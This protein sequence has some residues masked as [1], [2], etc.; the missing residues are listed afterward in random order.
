VPRQVHVVVVILRQPEVGQLGPSVGQDQDVVGLHVP[1]DHVPQVSVV[2]RLGNLRDDPH[3]VGLGQPALRQD[4]IPQVG[5]LDQFV[6]EIADRRVD[7]D[8]QRADD[9]RVFELRGGA[10]LLHQPLV[11]GQVLGHLGPQHLDRDRLAGR[12]I[13]GTVHRAHPAGA[14]L[15]AEFITGEGG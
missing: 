8:V 3:R 6:H 5:T 15:F 2:E 4:A 1:V 11:D 12:A 10:E 9:V 7:A 13:Q 14:D